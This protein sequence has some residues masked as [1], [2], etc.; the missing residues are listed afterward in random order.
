MLKKSGIIIHASPS[1]NHLDHGFYMFSPTL[2]NDY[3]STNK[4]EI[5]ES[6]LFEFRPLKYNVTSTIYE[7]VPGCLDK[8]SLVSGFSKCP[9]GIWSV[10]KKNAL[11]SCG[12]I[13]QQGYYVRTWNPVNVAPGSSQVKESKAKRI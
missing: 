8:F 13:P 4:Y 6:K 7:Y 11:S 10:A 5:I 12:K 1:T 9:L 2:F 3:Y